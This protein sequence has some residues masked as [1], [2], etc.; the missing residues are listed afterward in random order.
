MVMKMKSDK[1]TNCAN[2][3]CIVWNKEVNRMTT[4]KRL[5][6]DD[7]SIRGSC[8]ECRNFLPETL[9]GPF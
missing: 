3:K 8:D 9:Y 6:G 1:C 4:T 5:S 7:D 2:N